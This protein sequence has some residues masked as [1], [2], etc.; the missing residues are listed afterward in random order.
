MDYNLT[1]Q[2]MAFRDLARQFSETELL[3]HAAKWDSESYFPIEV[4]RAAG[5]LG[6]C[7]LYTSESMG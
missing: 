7:A 1:E 2:Q 4:I 3:P 5:D 6:F